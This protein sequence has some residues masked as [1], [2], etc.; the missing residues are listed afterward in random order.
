MPINPATFE[1]VRTLV[2]QRSAIVLEPGKEYLVESRLSQVARTQGFKSVDELA[3]HLAKHPFS[4]VHR[5]AVEAM[6]TNETSFFRDLHPFEAIK[7]TILPALITARAATQR[8]N[9]WSAACS[10]GQEPFTIAMLIREHFPQ[11]A[12]WKI[13]MFATDLSTAVLAKAR[14]GRFSQLEVNRGLPAPLLLKYFVKEGMEWV[15]R[16][17]IRSMIDF[18]ELN[19]AEKWPQLTPMDVVLMRNVLIYFDTQ[20]KK[21]ILRRVRQVIRPDGYFMLGSAET[22]MA[23]D[24]SYKRADVGRAVV[25]RLLGA[26]ARREHVGV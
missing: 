20:T 19:L 7:T 4:T 2:Q 16:E 3:D 17:D 1:Y 14:A 15:V 8:L 21:D 26:E 12:H 6:T 23:L 18:Q 24:D 5:R 10:S 25:Y 11:L 13:S 9:I 22:T